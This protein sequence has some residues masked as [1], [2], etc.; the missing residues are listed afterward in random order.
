[1]LAQAE[2]VVPIP[3]T[4]N[5]QRLEENVRSAEVVLTPDDL[6]RLDQAAPV[7]AVVGDRYEAVMMQLLNG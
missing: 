5:A 2:D 6:G 7:G 1:V 3:G 4:S